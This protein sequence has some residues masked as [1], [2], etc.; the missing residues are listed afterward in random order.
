MKKSPYK[1]EL[2][3]YKDKILKDL[4]EYKPYVYHISKYD[5]IYIKFENEQLRT[6]RLAD[7]SGR[8]KYKYKWNLNIVGSKLVEDDR[9]V[10]RFYYPVGQYQ[11]FINHFKNYAHKVI[12]NQL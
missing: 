12:G 10:V 2:H 5:S 6:I 3:K 8:V 11:E 7:H 1:K 4:V 9:G